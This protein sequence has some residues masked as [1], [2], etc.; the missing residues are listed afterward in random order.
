MIRVVLLITVFTFFSCEKNNEFLLETI[1]F[2]DLS[3]T[4]N[5]YSGAFGEGESITLEAYPNEFFEFVSWSG[6][7]SGNTPTITFIMNE[8]KLIYAEFR[9]KDSDGDGIS[10]DID[11][12]NDTPQGLLVNNEGCTSL[13]SDYD[14][15]GVINEFDICP[16][17]SPTTSV[18]KN[19]C[20]LIY[21]DENGITL[22]AT[23]EAI[24]SIGKTVLLEGDSIIIIRDWNHLRSLNPPNYKDNKLIVTTFLDKT[25]VICQ[26]PCAINDNFIMSSW[27]LSNVKSMYFTFWNLNGFDQDISEWDVSNVEDMEGLFFHS[28]NLNV[29][30]SSWNVSKVK[31]M[32]RMFRGAYYANPD[33][34]LWNVSNV[35]NMQEMFYET[36]LNQD[37]KQWDVKK[38]KNMEKMFYSAKYFNQDLSNW[39][40]DNVDSCDSFNEKAES[41]Q[42]PRPNFLNCDPD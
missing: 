20:P 35:E 5:I 11:L 8:N 18:S 9:K 26:T 22:K 42:L 29:D 16:N 19:G 10:D 34:S 12:C 4:L 6:S 33:V 39:N 37:L 2:P 25:D 32:K 14:N 31:N 13:Q 38:V 1:I 3:G 15:D 23:E 21:L 7:E 30:L 36:D 28:Y 17:T 40:V 41:W 27:D 24:D